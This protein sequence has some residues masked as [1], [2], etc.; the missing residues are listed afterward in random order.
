[1]RYWEDIQISA[2]SEVAVGRIARF[3]PPTSGGLVSVAL[4]VFP[5]R[6]R[7]NPLPCGKAPCLL[8]PGLS[9]PLNNGAIVPPLKL[10]CILPKLDLF[11]KF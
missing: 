10:D 5:R 9:S 11:R 1:M 4:T 3:T 8:L 7:R 6:W 2:N